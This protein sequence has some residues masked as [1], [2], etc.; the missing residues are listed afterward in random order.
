MSIWASFCSIYL[1][2]PRFLLLAGGA[3]AAPSLPPPLGAFT[4]GLPP[5]AGAFPP[6]AGAFPPVA[7]AFPPGAFP[8]GAFP[9]GSPPPET[10]AG[11]DGGA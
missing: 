6:V 10:P 11:G 5:E 3:G 2:P 8:P 9:P 4:A 7:G 1:C